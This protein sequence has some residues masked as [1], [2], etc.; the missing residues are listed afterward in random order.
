VCSWRYGKIPDKIDYQDSINEGSQEI[1][2]AKKRLED[3]I[4]NIML[5]LML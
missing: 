5:F 1:S 2:A 4:C 3:H